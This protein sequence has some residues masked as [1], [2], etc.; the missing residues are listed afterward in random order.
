MDEPL[1]ALDDTLR[2]QIIPY[3]KRSVSEQFGI[4]FLFISHSLLEMR[5]MTDSALVFEKGALTGQVSSEQ[6]ARIYV[7]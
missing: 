4:P 1:S 7:I 3:L 2:F 5:L 6:L